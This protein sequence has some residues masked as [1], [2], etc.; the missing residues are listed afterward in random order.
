MRNNTADKT[1]KYE[2]R[3]L[4]EL[5]EKVIP[6]F[7]NFPLKSSKQKDFLLFE[8]ICRKMK[9]E[10]HLNIEGFRKIVKLAFQMNGS[11]KRKYSEFDLL[12]S[13]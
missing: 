2:I 9:K 12:K 11:G 7:K 1:I 3:S 6:H 8:K 5:I 4:S 10:E 13:L